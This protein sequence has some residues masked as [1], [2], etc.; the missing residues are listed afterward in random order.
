MATDVTRPVVFIPFTGHYRSGGRTGVAQWLTAVF[1]LA[2]VDTSFVIS[3]GSAPDGYLQ[4]QA[5]VAGTVYN[6]SN[7]GSD[8]T[9][10]VIVLRASVAGTYRLW[11][12]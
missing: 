11:I 8:W 2:N 4:Y 1:A 10:N 5:S 12:D 6:G 3:L 9:P 7:Q